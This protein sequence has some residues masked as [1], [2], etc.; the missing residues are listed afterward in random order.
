MSQETKVV[1]QA[2]TIHSPPEEG[3][4]AEAELLLV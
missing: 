3:I 1:A 2:K 4:D